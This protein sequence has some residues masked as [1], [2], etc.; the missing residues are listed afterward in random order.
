MKKRIVS[1]ILASAFAVSAFSGCAA[2][3]AENLTDDIQKNPVPVYNYADGEEA[4]M[5]AQFSAQLLQQL[6]TEDKNGR[7]Y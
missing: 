5:V 2:V 1:L 3:K 7:A 4:Q 6:C